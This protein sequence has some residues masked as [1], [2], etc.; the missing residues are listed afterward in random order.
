MGLSIGH[1]LGIPFQKPK[2]WQSYCTPQNLTVKVLSDTSIKV[3]WTNVAASYYDGHSVERSD[4]GVTYAEVDTVAA[5]T[6]TYTDTVTNTGTLYY[7]RVRAYKG[8]TYSEYCAAVD[9]SKSIITMTIIQPATIDQCTMNYT[10]ATGKNVY[11]DWGYSPHVTLTADGTSKS[12]TSNYTTNNTTY[13]MKFYGQVEFITKWSIFE[14]VPLTVSSAQYKKMSGLTELTLWPIGGHSTINS[15]DLAEMTNLVKI[16]VNEV[17]AGVFNSADIS[18][19]NLTEFS[20]SYVSAITTTQIRSEDFVGM[21]LTRFSISNVNGTNII[22]TDDF[23]GMPLTYFKIVINDDDSVIK[24]SS[25][26]AMTNLATWIY[27]GGHT[28]GSTTIDTADFI[29]LPIKELN[30]GHTGANTTI[31]TADLAAM[32]LVNFYM[33]VNGGTYLIDFSD[34][35]AISSLRTVFI[36]AL[37]SGA[38]LDIG[39]AKVSDLPTGLTTLTI[40]GVI[41]NLDITTG[42]MKA[43]AGTTITMTNQNASADV[44]SFLIAWAATAGAGTKTITLKRARTSASDAAVATLNGLG[45][46]I[47]TSN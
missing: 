28:T 30:I 4:D 40:Q 32:P 26:S 31:D 43:W 15:A 9:T 24:S 25:F 37:A 16:Y 38:S 39:G 33:Y 13:T 18:S 1:G 7:Y 19:L 46:T 21:S 45:K 20:C 41:T 23:I 8:T 5:G 36:D 17:K 2:S 47:N 27:N 22:E 10:I 34:F 12:L 3:D 29:G 44:D 42:T 6:N 11:L 35:T 14:S